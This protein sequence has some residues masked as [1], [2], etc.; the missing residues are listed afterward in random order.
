MLRCRRGAQAPCPVQEAPAEP[1]PPTRT[2]GLAPQVCTEGT[3][4]GPLPDQAGGPRRQ[5][6]QCWDFLLQAMALPVARR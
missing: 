6:A 4:L 1:L 3:G 5:G 2:G